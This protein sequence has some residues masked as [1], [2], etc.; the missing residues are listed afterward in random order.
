MINVR[1]HEMRVWIISIVARGDLYGLAEIHRNDFAR[2]ASG[3]MKSVTT[4]AAA[5]VQDSLARESIERE[6][7]EV[8]AKVRLVIGQHFGESLPF[9]TEASRGVSLRFRR[10]IF[11]RLL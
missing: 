10:A 5:S 6:A 4:C 11:V 7:L 8:P 3:H 1:L 9:I 2:S